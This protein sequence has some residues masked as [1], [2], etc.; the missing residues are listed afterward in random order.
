MWFSEGQGKATA[1]KEFEGSQSRLIGPKRELREP[2]RKQ[3][4]LKKELREPQ[5]K[6]G[7]LQLGL[8]ELRG[9]WEGL[10]GS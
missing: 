7:R 1:S 3:G 4:G 8:G 10:R 2:P 6:L 5:K 9:S